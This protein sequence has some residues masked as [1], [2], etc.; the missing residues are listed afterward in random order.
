MSD[1]VEIKKKGRG[2]GSAHTLR[3]DFAG[4]AAAPFNDDARPPA[5]RSALSPSYD[6]GGRSRDRD[7]DGDRDRDEDP[8]AIEARNAARAARV[9]EEEA[10][11]RA[12]REQAREREEREREEREKWRREREAERQATEQR[13]QRERER[14]I[15][16]RLYVGNI[17]RDATD[18]QLEE[19]FE[20]PLR[21]RLVARAAAVKAKMPA[22]AAAP[23]SV[24]AAP[25]SPS[26]ADASVAEVEVPPEDTPIIRGV[27]MFSHRGYAFLDLI[28]EDA[29]TAG[30]GIGSGLALNGFRLKVSR[31]TDYRGPPDF[32]D[33]PEAERS[34]RHQRDGGSGGGASR[35]SRDRDR[36][37]VRDK[38]RD[39][40]GR[41][42][43][44]RRSHSHSPSRSR[45][46][47]RS[48]SGS[49]SRSRSPGGNGHRR[50]HN[51]AAGRD[52]SPSHSNGTN[53]NTTN[54]NSN[55]NPSATA[56][57]D[58]SGS[59]RRQSSHSR[60]RERDHDRP[61]QS[62]HRGGS[63]APDREPQQRRSRFAPR[64]V[65]N[66]GEA[67]CSFCQLFTSPYDSLIVM[68]VVLC[69]STAGAPAAWPSYSYVQRKEER[70]NY[71]LLGY[72][73]CG[74]RGS[75]CRPAREAASRG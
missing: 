57:A 68:Y 56:T 5:P 62:Q 14:D 35:F 36:D 59:M 1:G 48:G 9:A 71:R 15:N 12:A 55:D 17:P 54:A 65:D 6:G 73:R 52:R 21:D 63:S 51:L 37:R 39:R 4:A 45:S 26:A 46:R 60:E 7:R 50:D 40:R 25:T 30:V 70:A 24:T 10:A 18:V 75:G 67:M 29:A 42:R 38:D 33:D 44:R 69:R 53:T 8:A 23:T 34:R 47:S 66:T 28:S 58:R 2:F 64:F 20:R 72:L 74:V 43:E 27:Q 61:S 13:R 19:L 41:S 3:S 11:R 49:R 31:P 32:P 16:C 22:A